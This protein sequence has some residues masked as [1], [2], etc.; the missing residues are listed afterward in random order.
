MNRIRMLCRSI[1]CHL[2]LLT[3][4]AFPALAQNGPQVVADA[5]KAAH[6]LKTYLDEI[7]RAGG[8]P[9]YERPPAAQLVHSIF[10][11]D[12]L[13]KLPISRSDRPWLMEWAA[14]ASAA[15]GAI[16]EFG[17]RPGQPADEARLRQLRQNI[18]TDAYGNGLAFLLRIQGRMIAE[19]ERFGDL[20][21]PA[22]EV[23]RERTT[24]IVTDALIAVR[25]SPPSNGQAIAT[26]LRET[27]GAWIGFLSPHMRGEVLA[28]LLK[29]R[30]ETRDPAT[31]ESLD[32][33]SS[34]LVAAAARKD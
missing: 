17:L 22:I 11:A 31:G 9:D 12:A 2:I 4:L 16:T 27:D 30:A 28:H 13:A 24:K 26:A 7:V 5:A 20:R 23:V 34:D 29:T 21:D 1:L 10:D 14:A 8:R 3:A 33:V 18:D 6:Q 15:L 25:L 32:A 19:V